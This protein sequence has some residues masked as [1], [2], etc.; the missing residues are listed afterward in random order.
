MAQTDTVRVC[1]YNLLNYGN[2]A[3]PVTFK[4]P[5][6]RT[7][8]NYV[9]PDIFG[10]NEVRND[11]NLRRILADSV[12]GPDWGYGAYINTNNEIQTNMLFWKKSRFALKSQVSICHNLRDIIAYRLYYKDTAAIPSTD[13]VFFTVIVA[14]LKASN[15][16]QDAADRALET[17]DVVAYLNAS[18]KGNYLFMGDLNLYTSAE[19]AYQNLVGNPNLNGRLYDPISRP[20]SWSGN[21]SFTD[22]HTQA[23][24]TTTLGDGGVTGGLD[25]RFDHIM[26]SG[27]VMNDASGMK[28]LDASY[29]TPGQDGLHLNKA[30]IEAPVNTSAPS[31]VIQALYEMS[32]HLPVHASFVMNKRYRHVGIPVVAGRAGAA[33]VFAANPFSNEIRIFYPVNMQDQPL[34]ISLHALTGAVLFQ[35]RIST[36][37]GYTILQ[38]DVS[39]PAGMYLLKV[40][41]ASGQSRVLKLV[42]Q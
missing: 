22:I 23:T 37:G 21:T 13:T 19:V 12:L 1:Q 18:G 9:H 25:D 35:T 4:N 20:G 15:T 3:N 8:V 32:D 2:S 29:H 10:A 31:N 16:S 40:R 7:I 6:L 34:N 5:R 30:L 17:Q 24:R 38:P 28:Y 39:L 11:S 33:D 26:V 42:K 14:H 27:D 41:D 36:S